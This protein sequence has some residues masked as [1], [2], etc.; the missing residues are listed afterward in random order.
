MSSAI[1]TSHLTKRYAGT[2]L[3]IDDVSLTV[4]RGEIYG[5]VGPNGAGKSTLLRMM[6]GL[7]TPTGGTITGPETRAGTLIEAPGFHPGLSGRANLHAL[8]L[9]WGIPSG[10][11]ET[12]LD[13][14]RL[15][16][17]DADRRYRAYSLGM[18]QR[19]GIAAA[20]LA[21]PPL[22][23]LDEPTNG[24]DPTAIIEFRELV[25]EL[26]A[27][28]CAVVLSSHLLSEVELVAD[29]IGVLGR[30]KL[31]A[32]G[33]LE[34]LRSGAAAPRIDLTARPAERVAE[35]LASLGLAAESAGMDRYRVM[36]GE[37]PVHRVTAELVRAGAEVSHIAAVD[38]SLE[39]TFIH[40]TRPG[41][42]R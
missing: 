25:A 21:A 40:L 41:V 8:A 17:P 26:R 34:Q 16:I 15:S 5:L 6:A 4:D 32:E 13:R 22:I 37:V 12:A 7:V 39:D 1:T 11:V 20:I 42:Q 35:V 28:G 29:R 9:A 36:V 19:L 33:P 23:I 24:L 38:T 10:A 2:V 14:V 30:G 27:S 31:L 3:A 18:K